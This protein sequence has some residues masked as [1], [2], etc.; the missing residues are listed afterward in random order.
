MTELEALARAL[1]IVLPLEG[2]ADLPGGLW[3]APCG[4][5]T[6]HTSEQHE[7]KERDGD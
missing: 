4:I 3:C 1:S 5:R 7:E 2:D 6:N